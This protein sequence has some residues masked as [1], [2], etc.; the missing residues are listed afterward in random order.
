MSCP[1]SYMPFVLRKNINLFMTFRTNLRPCTFPRAL[2]NPFLSSRRSSFLD[3]VFL[4]CYLSAHFPLIYII[5]YIHPPTVASGLLNILSFKRFAILNFECCVCLMVT[6]S[7]LKFFSFQVG[8]QFRCIYLARIII[9]KNL[10]R[11]PVGERLRSRIATDAK[12]KN[13]YV[14][15]V[16]KCTKFSKQ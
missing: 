3:S 6:K 16:R 12:R 4:Q 11:A 15:S 5:I 14:N 1:T 2:L 9:I 8:I 13:G 7:R 10:P